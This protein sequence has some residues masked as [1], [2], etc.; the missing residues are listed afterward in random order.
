MPIGTASRGTWLISSRTDLEGVIDNIDE[1]AFPDV[2]VQQFVS[3]PNEHAQ[4]V[5]CNGRLVAMHAYRKIVAG[6]GGGPAV[7]E[8]VRR[9]LV[10]SH[11]KRIG[12]FLN[13]HGAL[14]VDYILDEAADRPFYIDCNPRLVEPINALLSGVDLT[15]LLVRISLGEAPP[16]IPDGREAVRTHLSIQALFG[17][18]LRTRSRLGLL[19]ECWQLLWHRGIYSGSREELTPFRWDWPG[20]IPTLVAA[21]WFLAS[22]R[23]A[24][25]ILAR[26]WGSNLLTAR[27]VNMI[28]NEVLFPV[29]R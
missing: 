11:L 20:A 22:P 1:E 12:A 18:A 25:R 7:K 28:K 8:S 23:S 29:S 4:A 21:S 27:T 6:A 17:C 15:H 5:F 24:P 3:G 16:E 26:A 2:L 9:P 13:W 19:H 14:S 10:R